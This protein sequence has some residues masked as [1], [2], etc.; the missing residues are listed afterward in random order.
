MSFVDRCQKVQKQINEQ[1]FQGLLVTNGENRYYLSGFRGSAG[2]LLITTGEVFLL[3]DFR[4]LQQGKQEAPNCKIVDQGK[5]PLGKLYHL[6]HEQKIKDLAF[7]KQHISHGQFLRF[8]EKL[9]GIELIGTENLVEQLREIKDYKEISF[10]K[11]AAL[12]ADQAFAQLIEVIKP[13]MKELEA[14]AH[15]EFFMRSLGSEGPAFDTIIASGHRSA[16]PHGIASSKAIEIGDMVVIDFGATYQGYRSD[17]T[18]TLIMGKASSKQ[19]EIYG[20]VLKAQLA[21]L[22]SLK[23]GQS[24]HDIDKT[25][26]EIIAA[27]GYGDAFGHS[28]GHGVGLDVHENPRLAQGNHLSLQDRMVVTVEPG[29]YLEN[30]GGVRIEDMVVITGDGHLNL[31]ETDKEILEIY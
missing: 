22:N 18:R 23:A 11:N 20:T 12:I 31:T 9:I 13:G 24:C 26:R 16:L 19:R 29:I 2:Y 30:E 6:L 1:G 3:T 8:Q 10:I 7:E 14:A 28:L 27:E 4:Y 17:M 5:D 21:A 15:L 25:A